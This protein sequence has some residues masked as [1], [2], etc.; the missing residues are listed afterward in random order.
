MSVHCTEECSGVRGGGDRAQVCVAG[1]SQACA[2][3][4]VPG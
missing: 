2:G 4:L 1:F 3:D